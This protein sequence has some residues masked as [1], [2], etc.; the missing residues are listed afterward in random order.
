[1]IFL[2]LVC[3]ALSLRAS[4]PALGNHKT[5]QPNGSVAKS[6][7]YCGSMSQYHLQPISVIKHP[8]KDFSMSSDHPLKP[9][10]LRGWRLCCP[11]CGKGALLYKYLKVHDSCQSCSQ[12]L[13]HHRADDGPA[14]LTILIVGHI[15]A[16]LLHIV[17]VKYRPEP[18]IMA[19]GFS[20]GCIWLSLYLLPRIKGSI[21]AFQWARRL[22]GFATDTSGK[23]F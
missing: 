10:L 9:A 22:N 16:P 2:Q 4:I 18:W 17:F 6:E 12:E 14:Y 19:F 5:H 20:L 7:K 13:Y 3:S 21:I 8:T 15:M 23:P 11:N 1:M